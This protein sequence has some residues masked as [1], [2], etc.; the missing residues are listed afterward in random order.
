ME[1]WLSESRTTPFG[2]D[3]RGDGDRMSLGASFIL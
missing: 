3:V 2:I 1:S